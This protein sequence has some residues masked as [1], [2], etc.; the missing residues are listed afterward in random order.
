MFNANDTRTK[1][2]NRTIADAEL[3]IGWIE[4]KLASNEKVWSAML[5]TFAQSI[6]STKLQLL[7]DDRP[8]E[9]VSV[10]QLLQDDRPLEQVS[11]AVLAPDPEPNEPQILKPIISNPTKNYSYLSSNKSFEMPVREI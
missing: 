7:Q 4:E 8:L 11:I 5:S 9:Q 3:E 6:N 1:N 10:L 2:L